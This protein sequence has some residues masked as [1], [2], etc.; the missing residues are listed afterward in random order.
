MLRALFII[1][2]IYIVSGSQN[3]FVDEYSYNPFRD[4]F[5]IMYLKLTGLCYYLDGNQF[6][7]PR[8]GPAFEIKESYITMWCHE[9]RKDL[10]KTW[11]QQIYDINVELAKTL[12]E[13]YFYTLKQVVRHYNDNPRSIYV[14][15]SL[16]VI[17]ED[18]NTGIRTDIITDDNNTDIRTYIITDDNNTGIRT[19]IIT[20]DNNFGI[21]TDYQPLVL[22]PTNKGTY[23]GTKF[24][25]TITKSIPTYY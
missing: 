3:A 7:E 24:Y 5:K 8:K 9:N 21:R 1:I 10:T 17:T 20:D 16:P 4:Q 22:E 6:H 14:H 18:N 11:T 23:R 25:F 13:P 2:C 15:T 12:K 19:D